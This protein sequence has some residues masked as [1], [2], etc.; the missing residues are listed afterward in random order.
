MTEEFTNPDDYRHYSPN[1]WPMNTG[2]DG[3][4]TPYG[5]GYI[6]LPEEQREQVEQRYAE[7]QA[8]AR[9]LQGLPASYQ[10]LIR[11]VDSV[12]GFLPEDARAK[13]VEVRKAMIHRGDASRIRAAAEAWYAVHADGSDGGN[14]PDQ[15]GSLAARVSRAAQH[16]TESAADVR[17]RWNGDS[18]EAMSRYVEARLAPRFRALQDRCKLVADVLIVLAEAIE[19]FESA[20]NS[21]AEKAYLGIAV[22]ALTAPFSGSIRSGIAAAAVSTTIYYIYDMLSAFQD[23]LEA[24]ERNLVAGGGDV[25][26]LGDQDWPRPIH[27]GIKIAGWANG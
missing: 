25:D 20:V 22:G 4:W 18:A 10:M 6:P 2:P 5:R 13:W 19:E 1:N 15:A 14:L 8:Y 12:E 7:N 24:C 23:L 3:Q 11:Q 26:V 17:V 21:T 16:T 27:S 9:E